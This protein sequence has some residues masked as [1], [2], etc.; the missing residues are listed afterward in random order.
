MSVAVNTNTR[1]Y[2]LG[3][4]KTWVSSAAT[5]LGNLF[6]VNNIGGWRAQ[7]P[8]P[9]HPSGHAIDLMINQPNTPAGFAQGDAI[10]NYAVQHYQELGIKY[11][12]WNRRYWDPHQGW[13]PY[14]QA[15]QP[16]HTD[17]VHITFNDQPGSWTG[18]NPNFTLTGAMLTATTMQPSSAPTDF[19]DLCAW[20]LNFPVAGSTCVFTKVFVREVS[21]WALIIVGGS[22]MVIALALIAVFTFKQAAF[23]TILPKQVKQTVNRVDVPGEVA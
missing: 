9:D 15:G 20:R 23:N 22:G 12:I 13:G 3:P 11:I 2:S 5:I 19:G 7:D 17:H 10:A 18:A 1:T 14:T 4:V 6:N 21:G 16:P 8:F